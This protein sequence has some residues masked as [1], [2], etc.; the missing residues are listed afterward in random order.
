MN[1]AFVIQHV[2]SNIVTCVGHPDFPLFQTLVEDHIYTS[3]EWDDQ[4]SK[5]QVGA[6]HSAYSNFGCH[7]LSG[8]ELSRVTN[9]CVFDLLN[10]YKIT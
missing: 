2:L 5:S 8:N 9:V 4:A 6:M 7:S 1:F 10:L 3:G